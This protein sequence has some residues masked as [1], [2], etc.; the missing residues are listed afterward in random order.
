MMPQLFP[1][2][3][4]TSIQ[5]KIKQ[6]RKEKRQGPFPAGRYGKSESPQ[7]AWTAVGRCRGQLGDGKRF[8]RLIGAQGTASCSA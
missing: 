2:V 6:K 3:Q 5:Y 8:A 7:K 1:T 4:F